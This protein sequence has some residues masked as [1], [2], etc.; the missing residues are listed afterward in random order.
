MLIIFFISSCSLNYTKLDNRKTYNSTGFAYIYD[1]EDYESAY[2]YAKKVSDTKIEWILDLKHWILCAVAA[3]EY[4]MTGKDK[5]F[6]DTKRYVAKREVDPETM[7]E[8]NAEIEKFVSIDELD[9]KKKRQDN[10]V[11]VLIVIS[12]VLGLGLL[13]FL[14]AIDA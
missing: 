7:R 9:Q 11:T 12:G 10:A 4:S 8:I 13:I 1:N 5:Y 14:A 2:F 3:R 6:L